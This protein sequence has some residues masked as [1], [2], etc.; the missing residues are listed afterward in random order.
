MTVSA[1]GMFVNR[2]TTLQPCS[3]GSLYWSSLNDKVEHLSII[4]GKS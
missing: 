1:A 2:E 3:Q 4:V